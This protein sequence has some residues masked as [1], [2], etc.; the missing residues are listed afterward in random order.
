MA[1]IRKTIPGLKPGS[2]Y[3]FTLKPKNTEIVATDSEQELIRVTVPEYSQT[4]QEITGLQVEKNFQTIIIKF[5]AVGNVDLDYYEYQI[6]DNDQGS[7]DPINAIMSSSRNKILVSGFNKAN[8]F[9]VSVDNTS[10]TINPVNQSTTSSVT[11]YWVRVRA[12]NTSGNPSTNWSSLVSSGQ[13]ELIADQFIG[14]LT[15]AKITA[16]TIG[17]HTI[18]LSGANS[19]IKSSI[20]SSTQGWQ[21]DGL[22]NATFNTATLRGQLSSGTNPNW[23]RV[24]SSGNI[25]SGASTYNDASSTFRVSNTGSLTA[26]LG[27]IGGWT[28]SSSAITSSN[29]QVTLSSNGTFTIGSSSTDRATITSTGDFFVTGT[30]GNPS[31]VGAGN[32]RFYGPWFNVKKGHDS[33]A[34]EANAQLTYR[35]LAFFTAAGGNPVTLGG[36]N[37]GGTGFLS[38]NGY[39]SAGGN[40]SAGTYVS[41]GGNISAGD[42]VSARAVDIGPTSTLYGGGSAKPGLRI[43]RYYYWAAVDHPG[44]GSQYETFIQFTNADSNVETAAMIISG[45]GV[46]YSGSSDKRMKENI[47]PLNNVLDIIKKIEPVEYNF[48]G[49]DKVHHGFI[50]QDLYSTYGHAVKVGDSKEEVEDPWGIDYGKLTPILMSGMKELLERVE[51]LESRLVQ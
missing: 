38:V 47:K 4:P 25:W 15:A 7:G 31:G 19:I 35:D 33:G 39:V 29:S 34:N 27:T 14:N 51:N 12:V 9:T 30:D 11:E 43:Q 41:A 42:T 40:L 28:I 44:Y 21:I 3:L 37:D 2:D 1:I 10:L 26:A 49:F 18:T 13:L 24:D 20:Y 50:A 48:I 32:S 22:G 45:G 36:G 46:Y 23:F 16:G 6:Y 5:N 17:A 8:V